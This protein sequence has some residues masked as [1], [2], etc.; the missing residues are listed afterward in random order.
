MIVKHEIYVPI[1]TFWTRLKFPA[2][3]L[4]EFITFKE[5]YSYLKCINSVHWRY[6]LHN[7]RRNHQTSHCHCAFGR[8]CH[9]LQHRVRMLSGLVPFGSLPLFRYSYPKTRIRNWQVSKFL[10]GTQ[11]VM[12]NSLQELK[13]ISDFH[14][15]IFNPL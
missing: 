4:N 2:G 14:A 15:L 13:N 10:I 3:T 8:G 7:C 9:R 5:F 1:A 12:L 6:R 11:F